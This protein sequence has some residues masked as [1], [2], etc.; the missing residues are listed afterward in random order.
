MWLIS[1]EFVFPGG[2]FYPNVAYHGS[3]LVVRQRAILGKASLPSMGLA[4]DPSVACVFLNKD[5][6]YRTGDHGFFVDV[7]AEHSRLKR[8]AEAAADLRQAEQLAS[9][10]P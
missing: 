8:L 5:F 4:R 3:G 10:R 1:G 9:K 2:D 7:D 6:E